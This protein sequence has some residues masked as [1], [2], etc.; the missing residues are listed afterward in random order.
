MRFY[1]RSTVL[2]VILTAVL[3][4]PVFGQTAT[5]AQVKLGSETAKNGFKN[6]DEIRDKLNNWRADDDAK[7]WLGAM[8]Y[9]LT[10]IEAIL[11]SSPIRTRRSGRSRSSGARWSRALD[12]AR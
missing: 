10:E 7:V 9:K 3:L 1:F 8:G 5:P 6:E 12:T 11:P 2:T 4:V